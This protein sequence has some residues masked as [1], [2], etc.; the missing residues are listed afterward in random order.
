MIRTLYYWTLI[1]LGAD[2]ADA[3][4][5]RIGRFIVTRSVVITRVPVCQLPRQLNHGSAVCSPIIR[6]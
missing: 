3:S 1:G 5:K 4:A 6:N 2:R